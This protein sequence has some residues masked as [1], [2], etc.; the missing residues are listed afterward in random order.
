MTTI[1]RATRHQPHA[2][3]R[4]LAVQWSIS[5]PAMHRARP[6]LVPSP[7]GPAVILSW[8]LAADRT[9]PLSGEAVL[10]DGP[11]VTP[12]LSLIGAHRAD[13]SIDIPGLLAVSFDGNGGAIR[14]A[15]TG[16]MSLWNL[17][18]GRYEL[19]QAPNCR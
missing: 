6:D 8:L 4:T 2:P 14:Y 17:P 3:A 11:R 1:A 9:S 16:L 5:R 13:A 18:G 10:V 19:L 7:T 15:R 12:L